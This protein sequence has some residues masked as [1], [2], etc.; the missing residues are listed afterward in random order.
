MRNI[1]FRQI[2]ATG[3]AAIALATVLAACG[4]SSS[5]DEAAGDPVFGGTL[6]FYDPIEYTAWTPV[7]SIW[8]NSQ[9]A[10]NLAERLTWQDPKTGQIKPW[11]AKSWE[12]SPDKQIHL[13]PA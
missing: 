11:L 13:P 3:T 7:N 5:P 1:R 12:V 2:L 8:S 10:N 4:G 9:V 6:N